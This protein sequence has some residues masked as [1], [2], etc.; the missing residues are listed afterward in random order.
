MA[1]VKGGG[2]HKANALTPIAHACSF[3]YIIIYYYELQINA[4]A[5]Y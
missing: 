3:L 1:F 4:I 2:V 5:S